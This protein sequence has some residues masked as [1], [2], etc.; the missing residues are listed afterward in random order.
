MIITFANK[1]AKTI[2][3][4]DKS[5]GTLVFVPSGGLGNRLRAVASAYHLAQTTGIG[6]QIYWFQD[7]ALHAP[8]RSLFQPSPLF[9]LIEGNAATALLYDRPRQRN[10]FISKLYQRI[11]FDQRID[12]WQVTPLKQQGFD[13]EAWAR[14]KRSYMSCYQDFGQF[15]NALYAQ[16]FHPVESIERAIARNMNKLGDHPIGIHIRR[17]DNLEATRRSPLHLFIDQM[18]ALLEEQPNLRFYLA[19]DDEPTKRQLRQ[20]FGNA[21]VTANNR[22]DRGTVEGIQAAVAEMYTLARTHCIYG[23]ADSSFSVIASRIGGNKLH[24]LEQK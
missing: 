2:M 24:I 11:S 9:H 4:E 14:G 5:N 13:F 8:F 17:T 15:P 19:T 7:W 10:L 16:L 1:K 20:R 3:S 18:Q 6:L 23:T 22:A 12:E 21:I